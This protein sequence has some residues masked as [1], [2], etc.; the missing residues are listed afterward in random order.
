[1]LNLP[2]DDNFS[3][4]SR[5]IRDKANGDNYWWTGP[6]FPWQTDGFFKDP[7]KRMIRSTYP[8][9]STKTHFM[10]LTPAQGFAL[11]KIV[12]KYSLHGELEIPL[13]RIP[14]QVFEE[15]PIWDE[16]RVG[17]VFLLAM[18]YHL[19]HLGKW[20][21]GPRLSAFRMKPYIYDDPLVP[22]GYDLGSG[23]RAPLLRIGDSLFTGD[24]NCGSGLEQ[25]MQS[26]RFFQCKLM[27]LSPK[28]HMNCDIRFL[29][30][31]RAARKKAKAIS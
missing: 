8:G 17:E 13:S 22:G 30:R 4:E 10:M 20:G 29:E 3:R 12:K 21:E 7:I 27:N 1:M 25:H 19:L 26:V 28:D 15:D 11:E 18:R 16:N 6:H 31:Q 23:K 24:P 9:F 2:Y 5:A 14:V